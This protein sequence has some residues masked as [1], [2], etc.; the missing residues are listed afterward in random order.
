MLFAN[1][2]LVAS[3]ICFVTGFMIIVEDF[4]FASKFSTKKIEVI[5][6]EAERLRGSLNDRI[7]EA[8]VADVQRTIDKKS[9]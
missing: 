9:Q 3:I 2:M 5:K 1:V 8:R 6:T 7:E 4:F